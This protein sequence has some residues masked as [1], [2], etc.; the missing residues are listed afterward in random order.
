MLDG[1]PKCIGSST[2]LGCQ[3][4]EFAISRLV[5]VF[6]VEH[7][8]LESLSLQ[9]TDSL[10]PDLVILHRLLEAYERLL[11]SA[12]D[13]VLAPS[14]EIY[15]ARTINVW[16]VQDVERLSYTRVF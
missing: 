15:F 10:I 14:T 6:L 4:N 12:C 1:A 7:A 9:L 5:E 16:I 11:L 2:I 3:I 13:V 8:A